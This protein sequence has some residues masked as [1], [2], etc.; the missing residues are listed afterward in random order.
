MT[1]KGIVN[2]HGKD[3]VTVARRVELAHEANEKTFTITTE[4]VQQDPVLIKATVITPKGTF[5]GYSASYGDPKKPIE[6]QSP[7][8]V[9]ETSAVGR[10]LGFA[11]YGVVEGLA[12]ADEMRKAEIQAPKGE[13]EIPPATD[14]EGAKPAGKKVCSAHDEPV[15]MYKGV[16]KTKLDD[17]GNPKSYWWHKDPEGKRICFGDGYQD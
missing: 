4:L 9:A 12:S 2:I 5:T 1:N 17:E 7:F 11:G 6:K 15:V 3:Y 16:S 10:A 8:E 13:E 14:E